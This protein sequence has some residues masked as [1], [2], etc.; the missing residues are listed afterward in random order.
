[1]EQDLRRALEPL[2]PEYIEDL[3]TIVD[4]E[5]PSDDMP[6]LISLQGW[7]RGYLEGRGIDVELLG[8]GDILHAHVH[9]GLEGRVV[10]IGHVDTVFPLGEGKRRPFRT[11][12]TRA[13]GP[14]VADMKG[15]VLLMAYALRALRA[16]AVPFGHVD[17]VIN[18]DEEIGSPRAHPV[19][20]E[21]ARGADAALVLE[22]GRENGA[23]VS[24]RKG[25]GD[26]LVRAH[27]RPAHAGVSPERGRSAIREVARCVEEIELLNGRL[28]GVTFNVGVI[29][30]GT[31]PNV[32]PEWAECEI[33][34]RTVR[35]SDEE[36][37]RRLLHE[38]IFPPRDADVEIRLEGDFHMPPM[39]RSDGTARLVEIARESARALGFEL[40]DIATGGGSDGNRVAAAGVPVL[41]ALGPV[42]GGAHT[43]QEYI[44]I[45]SVPERGALVAA[46]IARLAQAGGEGRPPE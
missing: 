4:Q 43:P 5:S 9:G 24:A 46:L 22:P 20:A 16:A 7:L 3:R 41:D 14:G 35:Q 12:G 8:D 34:V 30:G 17:I 18:S 15:G 40:Q 2:L 23:V 25:V 36:A 10:L 11:D 29:R 31:R 19:I 21:V 6:S 42:G 28:P 27:G 1:M 26:F 39:E 37:V 44:E 32:V 33:D 13:Y 38:A 45:S